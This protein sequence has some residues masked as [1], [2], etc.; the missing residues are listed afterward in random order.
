MFRRQ[1]FKISKCQISTSRHII[2][3][4]QRTSLSVMSTEQLRRFQLIPN[5]KKWKPTNHYFTDVQF[6]AG[7]VSIDWLHCCNGFHEVFLRMRIKILTAS[8]DW[9]LDFSSCQFILI[10]CIEI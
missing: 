7:G 4:I 9:H 3:L 6:M 10:I 8:L 2:I 1:I 5:A